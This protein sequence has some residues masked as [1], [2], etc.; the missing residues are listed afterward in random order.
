MS[1]TTIEVGSEGTRGW[2]TL[3]RP[4]KRNPLSATTTKR[5]VDAVTAQSVGI[6]RSWSDADVIVAALRDPESRRVA[7]SYLEKFGQRGQ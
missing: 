1:F 4:E 3:N 2:I 7:L 5:H 6:D